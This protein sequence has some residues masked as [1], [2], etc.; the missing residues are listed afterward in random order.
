MNL[1][2]IYSCFIQSDKSRGPDQPSQVF[3]CKSIKI[4]AQ[5]VQKI[6]WVKVQK[7]EIT[8]TIKSTNNNK[9]LKTFKK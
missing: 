7:I 5:P 9:N 6:F 3:I 1:I 4:S 8:F 2:Y